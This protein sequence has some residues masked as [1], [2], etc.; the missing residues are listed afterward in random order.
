MATAVVAALITSV[1]GRTPAGDA[2]LQ[3]QLATLLFDETR[4]REALEGFATPPIPT[5]HPSPFPPASGW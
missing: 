2:A 4:Y 1:Y 5:T 3:F